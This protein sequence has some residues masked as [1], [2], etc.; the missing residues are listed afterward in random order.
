[1]IW[2][3]LAT[4]G[5]L[6]VTC[7]LAAPG[8]A[9]AAFEQVAQTTPASNPPRLYIHIK[10]DS[11]RAAAEL[12]R[13]RVNGV[14]IGGGRLV[15]MATD[16]KPDSGVTRTEIRCFTKTDCALAPAV[17]LQAG[18]A[19]GGSPP[20]VRDMS[21]LYAGR[22]GTRPYHYEIWFDAKAFPASPEAAAADPAA[23]GS[24]VPAEKPAVSTRVADEPA[25][26]ALVL[27]QIKPDPLVAGERALVQFAATLFGDVGPGAALNRTLSH[28]LYLDIN[29]R[30]ARFERITTSAIPGPASASATASGAD[31]G[32]AVTVLVTGTVQLQRGDGPSRAFDSPISQPIFVG[33]F[34]DQDRQ[35]PVVLASVAVD[36]GQKLVFWGGVAATIA[37]FVGLI[38]V[39]YR[40]RA[41]LFARIAPSR[42]RKRASIA[43]LSA[44]EPPSAPARSV[45]LPRPP[46]ELLAALSQRSAVLV[47]GAGVSAQAGA[48]TLPQLVR[49]LIADGGAKVSPSLRR[50]KDAEV[51]QLGGAALD[52][53][54]SAMPREDLLNAARRHFE[55]PGDTGLHQQLLAAPWRGVI[56]LTFDLLVE[57]T[58][59]R[60]KKET[61][62]RIWTLEDGAEMSEGIRDPAPFLLKPFGSLDRPASVLFSADELQR[63]MYRASEAQRALNFLLQSNS[64]LFAGVPA[65]DLQALL[66]AIAPHATPSVRHFALMPDDPANDVLGLALERFGVQIIPYDAEQANAA[67]VGFSTALSRYGA[68]A[69]SGEAPAEAA[70]LQGVKLSNIGLFESLDLSFDRDVA[71]GGAPWTVLFGGNGVGKSTILKSIGLVL[72]GEDPAAVAAGCRLLRTGAKIGAIEVRLGGAILKTEL[73]RD[74][75]AV[76]VRSA[77]ISPVQAGTSLVMGFPALRG[78]PSVNP[79]GPTKLKTA[80][81]Q[82]P[83]LTPL[84]SGAVD[85]R[86][87][88]FK[89]WLVNVLVEARDGDPRAA[90]MKS[91]LE[92]LIREMVPGDIDRFAP[93]SGPDYE[94]LLESTAGPVAFDNLSQGMSSIFNWLGVLVQRL[95]DV[96]PDATTPEREAAIVMI[97]EI[98]SH[99]HPD[100]QRRLVELTKTHFPRVQILATSHSPLLAGALSKG[101][102]C[103][104]ERGGDGVIAVRSDLDLFGLRSQDILQGP[105]FGLTSDRAPRA[106]RE[107]HAFFEAFE[108]VEKTEADQVLLARLGPRLEAINYGKTPVADP[109]AALTP[110]D[111]DALKSLIGDPAKGAEP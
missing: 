15:A 6:M 3:R 92:M 8:R 14:G 110:S 16:L 84:V 53:L 75:T 61:P 76:S 107:I 35:S 21:A 78:A 52:A 20:P 100:W 99:L 71:D 29:G 103:V 85:D 102:L 86:L 50:L 69:P 77:Q 95:Y 73:R 34:R 45:P 31:K 109:L 39:G 65:A 43:A 54:L 24:T 72:A 82:V 88:S 4:V 42:R 41:L 13:K 12:F 98:D 47:L 96:Y 81:P 101:E 23:T 89:Q 51:D 108:K 97:D 62:W 68:S 33:S 64:F 83:D 70:Y 18:K 67:L 46:S 94:I 55:R 105:A 93:I 38:V 40:N 79:R 87:G 7:G 2:R 91:L 74:R 32:S 59:R 56:S 25:I 58:L 90:A 37:I 111:V 11:Q 5:F 48:P 17:A 28:S 26:T 19:L 36:G 104:L 27:S 49:Q 80:G 106:E 10:A 30:K 22:G 57:Q 63:Q 66:T 60:R 44:D 9:Q 1:M